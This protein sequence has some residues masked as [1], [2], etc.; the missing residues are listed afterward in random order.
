MV[1]ICPKTA[2]RHRC[3]LFRYAGDINACHR[4]ILARTMITA[5]YHRSRE[6]L[7]IIFPAAIFL[8]VMPVIRALIAAFA[9]IVVLVAGS[10]VMRIAGPF[11]I[12]RGSAH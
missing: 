9:G 8:I 12:G 6:R 4:F 3:P 11:I 7:M 10:V 1:S 5:R 2:D